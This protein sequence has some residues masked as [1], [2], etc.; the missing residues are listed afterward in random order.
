MTDTIAPPAAKRE[1]PTPV[2]VVLSLLAGLLLLGAILA[3]G[4]WMIHKPDCWENDRDGT[5]IGYD[6]TRPGCNG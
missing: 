5:R 4:S 6:Y 2:L 1:M 3:V